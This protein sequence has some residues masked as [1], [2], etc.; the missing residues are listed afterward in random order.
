MKL[1]NAVIV[2]IGYLMGVSLIMGIAEPIKWGI[3]SQTKSVKK[4]M[5]QNE[6][7]HTY[8]IQ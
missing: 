2:N 8:R 1:N 6:R 4:N 3:G 5:K 7:L